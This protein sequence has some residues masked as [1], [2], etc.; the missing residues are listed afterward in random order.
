MTELY[1]TN[2]SNSPSVDGSFPYIINQ[3]NSYTY[4]KVFFSEKFSISLESEI[5][6][7]SNIEIYGKHSIIKIINN[8]HF[9]VSDGSEFTINDLHIYEG[10]AEYGGCIYVNPSSHTCILNNVILNSNQAIYGGAIYTSGK[11]IVTNSNISDNQASKQGGAIWVNDNLIIINSI[12]NNNL[13]TELSNDNFGAA[14]VANQGLVVITESI[15]SNNKVAFSDLDE[16]VGGS[17]GAIYSFS[18]SI[19]IEKNSFISNNIAYSSGGIQIGKGDITINDSTICGNNSFIAGDAVGGGGITIMIGNV[20]INNSKLINNVTKG[21]FSGGI[22]SFLGNVTINNSTISG[23]VNRGPGGGIA[24]N[25]A[26]TISITN[27]KITDN[28][29]SSLGS[30]IV[31]FSGKLGQISIDNSI[32]ANNKLTNFQLIGQTIAAFLS[33]II[34]LINQ[35]L[36]QAK[37]TNSAGSNRFSESIPSLLILAEKTSI[38]LRSELPL[39]NLDDSPLQLD[40]RKILFLLRSTGGSIA[41]LLTC[42]ITINNSII[43]DNL[44]TEHVTDINSHYTALGGGVFSLSSKLTIN[45]T[46]FRHNKSTYNAS[47]IFSNRES[48]LENVSFYNNIISPSNLLEDSEESSLYNKKGVFINTNTGTSIFI[49]SSFCDSKQ[50]SIVNDGSLTLIN[51]CAKVHSDKPYINIRSCK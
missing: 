39:V 43:S 25:F 31:N 27:S 37:I 4:S 36:S 7:S 11:L 42:P 3:A 51:T 1:V 8:R 30:A 32:V 50:S 22:V 47:A 34:K 40:L 46:E 26:S 41:T 49:T 48:Q 5:L 14:I 33:V 44:V 18:A 17:A 21:M 9:N 16:S 35:S 24:A 29:G 10:T 45:N 23:N 20:I 38:D 28:T 13:I 6:I 2:D 12:I 15:I 19:I